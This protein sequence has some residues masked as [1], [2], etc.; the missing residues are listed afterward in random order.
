[1]HKDK[2]RHQSMLLRVPPL[3]RE[4]LLLNSSGNRKQVEGRVDEGPIISMSFLTNYHT[5]NYASEMFPSRLGAELPPARYYE[6]SQLAPG[7]I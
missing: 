5:A 4:F 6:R 1:M 2:R 3:R 7:R